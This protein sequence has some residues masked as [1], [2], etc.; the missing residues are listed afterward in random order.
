MNQT[1]P[2]NW[3]ESPT[4]VDIHFGMCVY[5][6]SVTQSQIDGMKVA[7]C[8]DIFR[9]SLPASSCNKQ[10]QIEGH[11]LII[12]PSPA[13]ATIFVKNLIQELLFQL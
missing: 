13:Q 3:Y 4:T 8:N 6:W 1:G 2:K 10:K 9:S 7:C 11:P 5:R 12:C